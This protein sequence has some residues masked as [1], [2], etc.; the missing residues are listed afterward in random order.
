M[1]TQPFS[2]MVDGA[3]GALICSLLWLAGTAAAQQPAGQQ[4]GQDLLELPLERF[5]V[6]P[7]RI[8]VQAGAAP[9][10]AAAAAPAPA[11]AP[12]ALQQVVTTVERQESTV[13]RSPA[14]VFV[15]TTEL[16]R[17][18]G[19]TTIADALLMVPGLDVARIDSSSWTISALGFIDRFP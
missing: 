14:A 4:A 9:A 10:A 17:R 6:E 16:I 12:L 18:S 5:A 8:A 11:V 1:R 15:V 13:A 19:A 7:V 2:R 3:R